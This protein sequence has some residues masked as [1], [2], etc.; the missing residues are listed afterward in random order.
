MNEFRKIPQPADRSQLPQYSIVPKR[1]GFVQ[2]HS[3]RGRFPA[4]HRAALEKRTNRTARVPFAPRPP[5][6]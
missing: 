1:A 5:D 3:I 2:K 4:G 6:Y